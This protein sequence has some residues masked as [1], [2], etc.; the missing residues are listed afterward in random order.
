MES[1][2]NKIIIAIDGYSSCGKSTIARQLAAKLSYTF[3]DSGAMYRA[4]TLFLLRHNIPVTDTEAVT[5][6]LSRIRLSF[7]WSDEKHAAVIQLNGEDV[8]EHIRLMN[9]AA[10]V[11][12]VASIA[13]VRRFA[14]AQQQA[15]GKAKGI[16]MDGR[17]IGTVVFPGAEL[18]IFVT[19]DPEVRARRRFDELA[20]QNIETTIE[21]VRK[22][23]QER[24]LMDTTR[25]ESPLRQAA[26]AYLLDNSAMTPE[27]QLDLVTALAMERMRQEY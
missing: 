9:V 3:I 7:R 11:S 20:A 1:T 23:L 12:Q 26:D 22:N 18:K 4:I 2:A 21:E 5:G 24:D 16:V 17:D 15:M 14:V 13:A 19:A 6:A 25:A 27:E 10:M 8:E